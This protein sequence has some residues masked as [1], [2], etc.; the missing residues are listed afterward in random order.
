[1]RLIFATNNNHKLDEIKCILGNKYKDYIFCMKDFNISIDPIEDG[2]SFLDNANIKSRALYDEM[3]S[4]NLLKQDDYIISDDTGL[5]IDY[6]DGAPGIYSARYLGKDVPQ[7]EKNN[8]ILE[9]MKDVAPVNRRAYFIRVLSV[10]WVVGDNIIKELSY[11]GKIYGDIARSIEKIG[12]FGYDP[13]F[14]VGDVS[15]LLNGT[16]KTYSNIGTIEKNKIS[17]RARAIQKFVFFL[18]KNHNIL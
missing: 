6:L 10:I 9:T 2:K 4:N 11:D 14:A 18:E 12:G 3:L 5:C 13:I 8:K 17:H 1:M 15:D 7:D 16:I